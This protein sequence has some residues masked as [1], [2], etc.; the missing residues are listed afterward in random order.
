MYEYT[1]EGRD[2]KTGKP[3]GG[4]DPQELRTIQDFDVKYALS[5]VRGVSEVAS[6]G[7]YVKEYQVDIDPNRMTANRV[8]ID[9]VMQAVSKSNLDIGAQTM[10]VNKVEYLIRGLGYIKNLDDLKESVVTVRDNVPIKV[11]DVAHVAYGPAP[12]RGGLDKD[13]ANAAGGV[14]V[15]RYGSNPMDVINNVKAKISQISAGLPQRTLE[16]GQISKVTIVPFYDRTGLIKETLGHSAVSPLPRNYDQHHRGH[17]IGA[18]P[19]RLH[20]HFQSP[21]PGRFDDFHC[22]ALF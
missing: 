18:Q 16:N 14:V 2:P 6:V 8:T 10:E 7:G 22:H 12:R 9:Q 13:G 19:A 4:W 5:S 20:C 15:A 3:T 1:L 11:K 21:A 17:H